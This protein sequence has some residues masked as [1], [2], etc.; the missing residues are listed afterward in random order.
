MTKASKIQKALCKLT[1]MEFARI[2]L[3]DEEIA[4]RSEGDGLSVVVHVHDEV[5]T[6]GSLTATASFTLK[7][8]TFACETVEAL[9]QEIGE[10]VRASLSGAAL[11]AGLEV[12]PAKS[13]GDRD[14]LIPEVVGIGMTKK[15]AR[16]TQRLIRSAA[17]RMKSLSP[18]DLRRTAVILQ[19]IQNAIKNK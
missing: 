8:K 18:G 3:D 19:A 4:F 12:Y 16:L 14:P 1:G 6:P 5:G 17:H 2:C 15:D 7:S 13:V 10:E 9:S 11:R